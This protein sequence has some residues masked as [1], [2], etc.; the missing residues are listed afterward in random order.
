[1][2]HD[3]DFSGFDWILTDQSIIIWSLQTKPQLRLHPNT[4]TLPWWVEAPHGWIH[5]V[6]SPPCTPWCG[7]K[8]RPAYDSACTRH[9]ARSS[10]RRGR[11]GRYWSATQPLLNSCKDHSFVQTYCCCHTTRYG[12]HS[13]SS[14]QARHDHT[15]TSSHTALCEHPHT[16]QSYRYRW[17]SRGTA[18][19]E[20]AGETTVITSI[21]LV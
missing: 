1:M 12:Y 14:P 2:K 5:N 15:H 13:L 4:P 21:S 20:Q 9:E 17:S 16:R 10:S 6:R 11:G 8:P 18:E 19:T 3:Q 7:G